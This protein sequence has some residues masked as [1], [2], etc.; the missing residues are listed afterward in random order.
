M[1]QASIRDKH[2][3]RRAKI[4]GLLGTLLVGLL[5][6]APASV[7]AV[8]LSGAVLVCPRELS[9]Q[10]S[11]AIDLLLDEIEK[12]TL[13]RWEV[14]NEWPSGSGPV[15]AVGP[16]DKVE[17]FAGPH[18][19]TVRS[20]PAFTAAEGFEI[21]TLNAQGGSPA[22]F[23]LGNDARGVLYGCGRLLRELTMRR[24]ELV[25]ANADSIQTAPEVPLRGHQLGYRP[26]TNS[27][28]AWTE[29]MWEQYIRDLAVFGVNAIELIPPR[30]DDDDDS[31]HFPLPKIDMMETMSRIAENYGLA[32]WIWYP[33]LDLDYSNAQTVEFALKE[34][35]EVFQRLPRIDVIFVPGGDPGHTQPKYMMNLLEKQKE[36]LNRYHPNAQV[37]M[38]PQSFDRE[39]MDEFL[40]IM[41]NDQPEWLGGIVFGPQNRISLPHLRKAIPPQY[42]IRRYPD[43]THNVRCQYAV[44]DWD[45]ALAT[46]LHRESINPRPTDEAMIFRLWKE[47]SYGFITYSEGCNDDVNK[48]VWSC[49]G[50][51]PDRDVVDILRDY[52]H[53]FIGEDY[54]ESFAQGLLALERNWRGPLLT[55]GLVYTTW[56]QFQVMEKQ[57]DPPT[58]LNWRFQQGLYR[59][60]YDAY[61]RRRLIYETELEQQ[62]MDVLRQADETGTAMAMDRAEGILDRAVTERVGEDRRSRVFELAEAL[63]QSIHMQLSVPRYKAIHVGRGANLD[64]IDGPLNDRLWLKNQF[65]NIRRLETVDQKLAAIDRIVNWSNPGPGGFYDNLGNVMQQPHL[66]RGV[67]WPTD[68]E[69]RESTRI[70]FMDD[71]SLRM[72]WRTFAESVYDAPLMMQYDDLNP[73]AKYRLRVVYSGDPGRP[74]QIKLMADRDYIVH[75]F[76]DKNGVSE[77]M[78]FEVPREATA[79]GSLTLAFYQTPGKG[80]SG[81]GCQVAE[82]WLLCSDGSE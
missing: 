18:A 34:W 38:S 77:P 48:I 75:D 71:P 14:T 19:Q 46:T 49:L 60:Y 56:E 26:K 35:A 59:A 21:F 73:H 58:L 81:R 70:G 76:L 39:W 69:Y 2:I 8:D 50:W 9:V 15:V 68:P 6:T 78:E 24:H 41:Q 55:N 1:K 17:G 27:Y 12:R 7:S 82:V 51:S 52:S 63:Y 57:A 79:D 37:W 4:S 64:S 33:A 44:P 3:N 65:A 66:I 29:A 32:V 72:S 45:V 62:A 36:S 67:G 40:S 43:I 5:L 25:L 13:I 80:G 22:V 54:T 16:R 28:D 42:P 74:T 47:E 20:R 61:I 23:V 53:Y 30:S 11:H 10:E 31:P